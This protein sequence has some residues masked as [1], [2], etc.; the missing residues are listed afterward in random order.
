[1]RPKLT[2]KKSKTFQNHSSFSRSKNLLAPGRSWLA[3]RMTA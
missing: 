3:G 1:M 2:M